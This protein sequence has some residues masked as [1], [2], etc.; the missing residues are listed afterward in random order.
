MVENIKK[1]PNLRDKS[2]FLG[3]VMS[4]STNRADRKYAI[5]EVPV[6][7][8]GSRFIVLPSKEDTHDIMLLED[9]IKFNLPDIFNFMGY[10]EFQAHIFKFTRDAELDIDNSDTTTIIQKLE[11][12]LKNRKKGKP[13]RLAY[14][15]N[16]DP[17]FLEYLLTRLGLSKTDNIMPGGSIHNFRHF[18]EFPSQVFSN[19]AKRKQPFTHPLLLDERVGDVLLKRDVLLNFP[20]HSFTPVIDMIR[21]AA[22]DPDVVSIKIACYRVASQSKIINAL[23]NA[24][25]NGK[26][27]TVMMELKARFDEEANLNWQQVLTDIGAKVL[28]GIQDMKVHA[29]ICVIKKRIKNKIIHYGFVSTG[30]VNEKTAKLY[31]DHCLLTSNRFI[32]ADV[33]RIFNFLQKPDTGLH[34]LEKCR[35]LIPSPTFI[36]TELNK[37]IDYEITAARKGH[38]AEIILKMNSM[39]DAKLIE[40]LTEAAKAGVT[41]KLIVRGIFC[42][43]SESKKFKHPIK[44]ISIIDE[45]LEHARVW[46]FHNRGNHKVYI[47]S[48]DWMI[49]NI[50]HRVEA[51]CPI[52]SPQLKQELIDILNIQL[53][54][55]TKARILNNELNNEYVKKKDNEVIR[56][57]EES[58]NYLVN[59]SY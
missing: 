43:Q 42:M 41:I 38:T 39:A 3:V 52:K 32:M 59:K 34:F 51:T 23:V 45:Y 58:Y 5:I 37:L 55:N 9:A 20:Y 53:K 27:V 25:R 10:D 56:S 28:T 13:I 11:K 19:R 48:A 12:G 14:D 26:D 57:Q 21:E 2:I 6:T 46:V 54:D 24:V 22:F 30:N 31:G 18:M 16:I 29:K 4:K 40:K 44:A 49:R 50:E 17:G 8:V 36:R 15:E 1:F 47:S 33:N 7:A 35:T